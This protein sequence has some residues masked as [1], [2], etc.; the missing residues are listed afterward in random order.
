MTF[1]M[2]SELVNLEKQGLIELKPR[3]KEPSD[4]SLNSSD[5][6]WPIPSPDMFYGLAGEMVKAIEPHTEADPVA[7][8][9]QTLAVFGNIAGRGAYY[10]VEADKHYPNIFACLIGG[11]SKGRKGTSL[12]QVRRP[13][14]TITPEWQDRILQGLSS[15]EGLIWAVRDAVR[16]GETIL[17]EGVTDK[18]LLIVEPEFASVLKA[19]GREGNTLSAILR[20]AWDS[21]ALR[22][23]TKNSP[24]KATDSHISLI[25]H[26]TQEE[27]LRYLNSTEAANGFANRFLW[28]CVR[29]SKC[30]PRGGQIHKVDFGPILRGLRESIEFVQNAGRIEPCEKTWQTWD[31]IYPELSEG[32]PGLLGA[33]ISRAEAQVMR[34]AMLY[35]LLDKSSEINPDHLTAALALWDYALESA[36]YIFGDT[37]GNPTADEIFNALRNNSQ[38]LTRTAIY[39]LFGRNKRSAEIAQALNHL[40]KRGLVVSREIETEGRHSELWLAKEAKEDK[41]KV[42]L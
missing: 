36:K 6:S 7:L 23:V 1:D 8:L 40:A 25:A 2:G 42:V 30:L 41:R 20:Q 9:I 22:T 39:N 16:K 12:G 19:A 21:G 29:R 38:G 18:R 13:F 15:G 5:S 26:I 37:V 11:T 10:Q 32:R 24:A 34:L 28:V 17:D 35:A 27:L 31:K 4:N 33:V 3:E 14:D